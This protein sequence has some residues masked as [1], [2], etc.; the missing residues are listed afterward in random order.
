MSRSRRVLIL[1]VFSLAML[2]NALAIDA[3]GGVSIGQSLEDARPLIVD[4]CNATSVQE[5]RGADAAPAKDVQTQ[6]TCHG[7]KIYQRENTVEYMFNDGVL[8]FVWLILEPDVLT[9]MEPQLLAQYGAI[10]YQ[11]DAYRVF[12]NGAVALRNDPPEILIASKEMMRDITGLP[13][14]E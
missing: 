4:A 11:N 14:P 6:I 5:Y 9:L 7:L 8:A 1:P 2:G 13:I 12:E 10:A 3:P